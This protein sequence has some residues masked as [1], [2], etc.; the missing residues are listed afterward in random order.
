V[1]HQWQ[2]PQNPGSPS[3]CP[4]IANLTSPHLSKPTILTYICDG[5]EAKIVDLGDLTYNFRPL[6]PQT[7]DLSR[8]VRDSLR[9]FSWCNKSDGFESTFIGGRGPVLGFRGGTTLCHGS[10][11][12]PMAKRLNHLH[13]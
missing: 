3:G 10:P 9:D 8:F 1:L 6:A 12:R 13:F 5:P 7:M 4:S 11:G 2:L